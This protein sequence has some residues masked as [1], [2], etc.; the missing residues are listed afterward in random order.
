MINQ[1][2]RFCH[3]FNE[4]V[5]LYGRVREAVEETIRICLSKDVLKEYLGRLLEDFKE[6]KL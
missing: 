3:V 6:G 2:V 4:Q 1:Y 5:K